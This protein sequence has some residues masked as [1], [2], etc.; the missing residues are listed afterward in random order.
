M[1]A[2]WHP[3]AHHFG[4][5]TYDHCSTEGCDDPTHMAPEEGPERDA[6]EEES[7]VREADKASKRAEGK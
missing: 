6:A 2:P 7:R 3:T 5:H 1:R 4:W